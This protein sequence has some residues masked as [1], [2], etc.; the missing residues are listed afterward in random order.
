MKKLLFISSVLLSAYAFP[1]FTVSADIPTYL[2]DSEVYL[3][4]FNG[5]KEILYSKA[6]ITN[7]KAVFKVDKKYIGMMRAFFQKSNSSINMASENSNINFKV[8][9][10]SK[11]KISNV[12][13]TDATNQLFSNDV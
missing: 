6:K 12:F 5:S 3:Y 2:A 11:N 8:E 4:G 10:D 1:Q 9:L 13:F 7:N